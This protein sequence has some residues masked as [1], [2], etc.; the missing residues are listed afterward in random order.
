MLG[1][2]STGRVVTKAH[3]GLHGRSARGNRMQ[4]DSQA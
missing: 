3:C 4:N 2:G 1:E